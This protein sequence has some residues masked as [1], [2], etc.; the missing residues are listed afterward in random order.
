MHQLIPLITGSRMLKNFSIW[1]PGLLAR[2]LQNFSENFFRLVN[3]SLADSE[4]GE[5][6]RGYG[7][8]TFYCGGGQ[9]NWFRSSLKATC[10]LLFI[11]FFFKLTYGFIFINQAVKILIFWEEEN[12]FYAAATLNCL[13]ICLCLI[14]NNNNNNRLNQTKWWVRFSSLSIFF[15]QFKFKS[16]IKLLELFLEFKTETTG[17]DTS[18]WW[19]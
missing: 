9:R 5:K 18:W 15:S 3:Y 7:Y 13:F 1:A 4:G 10:A 2:C 19:R 12:N 11:N 16:I 6:L 17:I 14:N 8:T